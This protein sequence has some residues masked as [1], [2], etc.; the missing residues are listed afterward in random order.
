MHMVSQKLLSSTTRAI[1][2]ALLVGALCASCDPTLTE[3]EYAKKKNSSFSISPTSLSL[4]ATRSSQLTAALVVSEPILWSTSSDKIATVSSGLVS[5][6]GAGSATITATTQSS[7][8]IATCSVIVKPYAT[9]STLAGSSSP[10]STEGIGSAAGFSYPSGLVVDSSGT[11][12]VADYNNHKIRKISPAGVVTTLVTSPA[13]YN[14]IGIAVDGTGNIFVTTEYGQVVYKITSTGTV[15]TLAGTGYAGS[16]D[17]T[18][19]VARFT[20]PRG[21]AIDGSGNLYVADYSNHK[22]RMISSVGVVTTLAGSGTSGFANGTGTA[23]SFNYPEGVAVDGSG[24]VYV[25][26]NGNDMIRKIS[27]TGV[28]TTLAGSRSY[29]STDGTGS[30]ASFHDPVAVAVDSAGNV[31]VADYGNNK[32]RKISPEGVVTTLAGSGSSYY[33]DGTDTNASFYSLQGIAVNASNT[34]YVTDGN[35]IR[36]I[37]QAE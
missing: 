33:M 32:I 8:L 23:A 7:G 12:Y 30:A 19:T 14:P 22:I 2:L 16:T 9:V 26:D 11:I 35:K 36:K 34:L 25:A 15:T 6:V 4:Y 29:G 3:G 37:T 20:N 1:A 21:I 31:Y 13:I 5:G 17:G 10:G 24:N 18:G 27:P 28:V